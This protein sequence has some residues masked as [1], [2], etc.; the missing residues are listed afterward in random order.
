MVKNKSGGNRAK[1]FARKN[2]NNSERSQRLRLSECDEEVYACV[3]KL[4]GNTCAL[5]TITGMNLVGHIRSKFSGRNKRGNLIGTNTIVLVGLRDWESTPKNCDILEVYSPN[6]VDQLKTIP[7]VGFE[8]L[9]PYITNT[10]NSTSMS[11]SD[12]AYNFGYSTNS[13]N[14]M[15]SIAEENTLDTIKVAAFDLQE[16]DEIDIDDI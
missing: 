12:A 8:R 5:T 9:Y 13:A 7:K 6:E 16:A 1:S 15:T 10:D 4:H 2:E 11:E 14:E 3:T